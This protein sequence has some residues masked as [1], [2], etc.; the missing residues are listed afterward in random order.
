MVSTNQEG[1]S[2]YDELS[3]K[4]TESVEDRMKVCFDIQRNKLGF[5]S[6]V[7]RR[8]AATRPA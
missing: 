3:E 7:S 2:D 5:C 8:A 1:N 6:K 4:Q